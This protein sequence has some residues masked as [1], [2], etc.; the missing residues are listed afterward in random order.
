MLRATDFWRRSRQALRR[1]PRGRHLRG[2]L[3]LEWLEERLAPAADTLD[4]ALTLPLD[5]ARRA[6]LSAELVGPDDVRLY[7]VH[8]PAGSD[9]AARVT[10][11]RPASGLV[12]VLRV[13]DA[14]GNVHRAEVPGEGPGAALCQQPGA[15]RRAGPLAP[16]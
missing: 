6:E 2:R 3:A 5:A 9:L 4:T 11:R 16:A 12:S 14:D 7:R 1:Q 10:A 15:G 8:V 13:F